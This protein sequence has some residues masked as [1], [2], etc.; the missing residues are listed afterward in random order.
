[1]TPA[2]IFG[3]DEAEARLSTID[4]LPPLREVIAA[5]GLAAKKAL[6]QNFLLDLNLTAQ[7]RPGGGRSVGLRRARGRPRPRRPDP[8]AAGRRRAPRRG[9]REGRALPARAGRDRRRLSGAAEVLRGRR[10]RRSTCAAHLTAA[11]ARSSRTC[12]TTSAPSLLIRWLTPPA[13]PPFWDS[14]TLMFQR[15]WP[16]GSWRSP[17]ARPTAGSR[18]G[19]V[20]LRARGSSWTCRPRPSPRRPRC[21]SAVVQLTALPAPRFPADPKRLSRVVGAWRSTSGARC[22]APACGALR[23]DIEALLAA[24]GIPPTD[25]AETRAARGVLR[26]SRRSLRGRRLTP[27]PRA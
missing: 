25:R 16:S 6:G 14:L 8:R 10:A 23:P 21:H 27:P 3:P 24:A 11:G 13:W 2:G 18:P 20:A 17:A 12:P 4:G 22:C 9:G 15:R 5:H 19:A 1:M 7:D 26:A